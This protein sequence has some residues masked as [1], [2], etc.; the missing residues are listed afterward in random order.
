MHQALAKEHTNNISYNFFTGYAVRTYGLPQQLSNKEST[1]Q[2]RRLGLVPQLGNIHLRRIWQP[3]LVFLPGKSHAQR[4]LVGYNS[5]GC[6]ESDMAEQLK[7]NNN[8]QEFQFTLWKAV[9]P[10]LSQFSKL[11]NSHLSDFK[12]IALSHCTTQENF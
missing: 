7:N 5:Q 12:A 6:K 8:N 11:V 10:S 1:C 3:V 4:N 9:A 2:C